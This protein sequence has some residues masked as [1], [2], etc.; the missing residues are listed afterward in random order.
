MPT[1]KPP[2][3]RTITEEM[4]K[5]ERTPEMIPVTVERTVAEI[6]IGGHG[7]NALVAAMR[8]I[9]QYEA[10]HEDGGK[11]RFGGTTIQVTY[12][13]DGDGPGLAE[14]LQGRHPAILNAYRNQV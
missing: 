12:T 13:P 1:G 4:M 9:G 10:D 11:Y 6:E 2:I 14:W 8:A 5:T 7:E 3:H